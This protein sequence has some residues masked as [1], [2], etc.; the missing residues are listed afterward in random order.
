VSKHNSGTVSV[1][2]LLDVEL[3]D[4]N[5]KTSQFSGRNR[6]GLNR[7]V[8]FHDIPDHLKSLKICQNLYNRWESQE[9]QKVVVR[10]GLK[11]VSEPPTYL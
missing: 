2:E 7:S 8:N 10:R 4:I 1:F 3:D 9:V 5:S 6:D 11:H